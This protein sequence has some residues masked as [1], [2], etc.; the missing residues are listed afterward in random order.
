MK[1]TFVC[2]F[3]V[4]EEG[5]R[6]AQ[7]VNDDGRPVSL[8]ISNVIKTRK[9]AHMNRNYR[10][11]ALILAIV[12]ATLVLVFVGGHGGSPAPLGF[13]TVAA[14]VITFFHFIADPS[15]KANEAHEKDMRLRAAIA[16]AVIVQY[17][18]MV[19]LAA[20]FIN[21]IETLPALTETMISSFTAIVAVVVAFYFGSS[22]YIDV[23]R[24][25]N[26]ESDVGKTDK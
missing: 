20:Y 4:D 1:E 5:R 21:D 3:E 10:V 23:K 14:G 18:V 25:G 11:A 17:L 6:S 2:K 12:G 15:N 13:C 16:S 26:R 7:S 9:R 19:G 22:A 8:E 24:Q